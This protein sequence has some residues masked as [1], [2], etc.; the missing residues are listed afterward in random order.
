MIIEKTT[1]GAIPELYLS[2]FPDQFKTEKYKTTNKDY[3][4][5]TMDFFAN[6]TYA[7]YMVNKD[8]FS[9]NYNLVKGVMEREDYFGDDGLRDFIDTLQ[10]DLDIPQ[11]MKHYPILNPPLNEMVGGLSKKKNS[12]RAKALDHNSRNEEMEN[13]TQIMWDIIMEQARQD[14]LDEMKENGSLEEMQNI[15]DP[16]QQQIAAKQMQEELAK[17]VQNDLIDYTS[18]AERWANHIIDAIKIECNIKELAE[19]MLRDFLTCSRMFTLIDED[20]SARGFCIEEINPKNVKLFRSPDKKYSK[21]S[22]AV[23]I[24]NIMDITEIIEKFPDITKEEVDHLKKSYQDTYLPASTPSNLNTSK[25][26]IETINYYPYSPLIEQE[27]LIL[28]SEI[29]EDGETDDIRD[30]LN[31]RVPN[32]GIFGYKY[33]VVRAYWWGKTLLREIEYLDEGGEVKTITVDENFKIDSIPD[34]NLISVTEGWVNRMYKGYK[35]GVDVYALKPFKILPYI[36]LIGGVFDNK[37]SSV[38]SLVDL[39]KPFQVLYNIVVNQLYKLLAK[40]K[41]KVIKV[42]MSRIPIPKDADPQ[43]AID[44]WE[45][46]A[47]ERGIVFEHDT[48]ETMKMLGNTNVTQALDLDLSQQIQTRITLAQEIKLEC[49]ELV[50]F[51]RQRLASATPGETATANQN[52]LNISYT[53]TEPYYIIHRYVMNQLYQ[54]IVDAAKYIETQKPTSTLSYINDK[55]EAAF[56]QVSRDELMGRDIGVYVTSSEEDDEIFR[57]LQSLS[58]HVLQNGGD[59]FDITELYTTNS[60]RS[61]Q[62]VFK[63]LKD[64]REAIENYQRNLEQNAQKIQQQEIAAKIQQEQIEADKERQFEHLEKE[65]DRLNKKEV[66]LIQAY[67]RNENALQDNN[68]NGIADALEVTRQ[69]AEEKAANR[70]YSIKQQQTD[71]QERARQDKLLVE[72]QKIAMERDKLQTQ[73]QIEKI[74]LKNPVVGESKKKSSK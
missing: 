42:Q 20:N 38:K 25:T 47:R 35:I 55:G 36:P 59:L 30:V 24:V 33:V 16:Q 7:Q 17:K 34:E 52:A 62:R 13:R 66:A 23:C 51:T 28:Q 68:A 29:S 48:P 44:I 8:T 31:L 71:I 11:W 21:D 67:G 4:K 50:G 70:D 41:G 53:Q 14:L 3:I 19:E 73:L 5:Q 2:S 10:R 61:L 69:Q 57:Q 60:I 58:Q 40:D 15:T 72:L 6:A 12:H 56:I 26:G 65:L 32:P 74:K 22:Y 63:S 1:T 9:K 45:Q 43:D 54:A 49:W 46:E 64:K 27:R 39:M 18:T 37:N